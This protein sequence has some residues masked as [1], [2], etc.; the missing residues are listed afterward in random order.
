MAVA[1]FLLDVSDVLLCILSF[2]FSFFARLLQSVS[3]VREQARQATWR[4]CQLLLG[5]WSLG[6]CVYW[7]QLVSVCVR[8]TLDEKADPVR[9]TMRPPSEDSGRRLERAERNEREHE[10]ERETVNA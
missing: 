9:W 7:Q 8:V 1:F 10:W 5:E 6:Q 4:E 3:V 2:A